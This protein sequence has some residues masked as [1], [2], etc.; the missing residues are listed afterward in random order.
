[1]R[2]FNSYALSRIKLYEVESH[3]EEIDALAD[4]GGWSDTL[5]EQALLAAQELL[6]RLQVIVHT[7]E[8]S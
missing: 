5:S 7:A 2:T 3:L 8:P 4:A 1:M 6:R